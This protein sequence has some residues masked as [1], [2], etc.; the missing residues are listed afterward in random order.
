MIRIANSIPATSTNQTSISPSLPCSRCG[1]SNQAR[2]F[3]SRT[4]DLQTTTIRSVSYRR[5]HEKVI[6][7]CNRPTATTPQS[8]RRLRCRRCP[9]PRTRQYMSS[10]DVERIT[11]L[12]CFSDILLDPAYIRCRCNVQVTVLAILPR[13]SARNQIAW[14]YGW[15]KVDQ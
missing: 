13:F 14:H 1:I 10:V 7:I 15:Q 3:V 5:Y 11:A 9:K 2:R 8:S 4:Q 6:Y 12:V